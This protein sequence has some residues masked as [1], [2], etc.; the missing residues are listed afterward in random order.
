MMRPSATVILVGL[1]S[2]CARDDAEHHYLDGLEVIEDL[3]EPICAGTFAFLER[4]LSMLERVTGLPRD[5]QGLVFYWIYAREEIGR[6]CVQPAGACARGRDFYG[7][8]ISYTHE[9]VHAH[10]HRLGRPRVWLVE[11]MAVMLDDELPP[12]A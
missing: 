9:L 10:L 1:V 4:R 2:A 12:G 6:Y 8:L 11:G 7:P 3:D 5:P